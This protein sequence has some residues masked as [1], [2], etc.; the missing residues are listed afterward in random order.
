MASST[1]QTNPYDLDKLLEECHLGTIQ[2]PDFDV[3]GFGMR[4]V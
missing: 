3:V 4:I 2:L 1:F